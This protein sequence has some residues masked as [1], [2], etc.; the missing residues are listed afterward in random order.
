ME[1]ESGWHD[2]RDGNEESICYTL[3][4]L[5]TAAN[6]SGRYAFTY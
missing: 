1:S 5:H 6:Q 4:T 2:G 3:F